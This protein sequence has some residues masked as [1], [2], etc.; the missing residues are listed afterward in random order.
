MLRRPMRT[1]RFALIALLFVSFAR[2]TILRAAPA[3][4]PP[5]AGKAR[6]AVFTLKQSLNES[7]PE[8]G[9]PIFEQPGT[10][11]RQF[12]SRLKKAAEDPNVKAVVLLDE[13]GMFGFAQVEE[14]RQALKGVR[15]AGKDVYVHADYIR[16]LQFPLY[17]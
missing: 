2:A 1:I 6:V 11:L 3:T 7:P 5:S 10:T 12:T 4:Q 16:T 15:D 17:A 14:M 9:L 13:G 8:E